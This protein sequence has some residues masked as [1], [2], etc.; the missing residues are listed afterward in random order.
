[1]RPDT[2]TQPPHAQLKLQQGI[3]HADPANIART[4][5]FFIAGHTHQ[6][7]KRAAVG[8][9]GYVLDPFSHEAVANY[10]KSV[11]GPLVGAFG[12][13]PPYAIFSDSLEAYGADW[14]PDLPAE[15]LKRR[16][17]DLIPHLAELLQGGSI[18]ADTVR[19]DYGKTL[20]ELVNENYLTQMTDW[21]VAHHT[22]FRSQ[23]YGTPAVSFSSQNLASLAEGEGAAV[24]LF[25]DTP[26]GNLRQS[27]LRSRHHVRRDLHLAAL[28]RLPCDTARHEG[29]GGHRLH[30]GREP[31]HLPRLAVLTAAGRTSPAG[32]STRPRR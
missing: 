27:R 6:Q 16:G 24:A 2:G 18:Q 1:M 4:V 10:L 12:N 28:A 31:V 17:Y 14:T 8:A 25:L 5:L 11:G 19:H 20:T 13:T 3:V 7:V 15:F 29:R 21:A 22:R 30:H 32:R 26:L 9:E 23:T